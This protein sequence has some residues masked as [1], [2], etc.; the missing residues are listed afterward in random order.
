MARINTN[1]KGRR[2][3]LRAIGYL[4]SEGYTVG[5]VTRHVVQSRGGP[6]TVA[7]DFFGCI[8]LIAKKAGERTRWIQV[9]SATGITK[10][11]E[12]FTLVPWTP[13]HDSVE[14]WRWVEGKGRDARNGKSR[15]HHYFKVYCSDDG[16]EHNP[17]RNIYPGAL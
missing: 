16:Y 15:P 14:L 2:L 12:E 1:R 3:E 11:V 5:S 17:A 10:R 7:G 6:M 8:D 4:E 13:Q 9:T